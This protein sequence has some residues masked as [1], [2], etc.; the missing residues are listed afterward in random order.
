VL[1]ILVIMVMLGSCAAPSPHPARGSSTAP[2]AHT[3]LAVSVPLGGEV[4][5]LAAGGGYLWAY[6]RDTGVLV[7]VDQRTGQAWRFVL[8]A[9][10]GMPVVVA[11]GPH[12]L[13]LA[14]QHSTRPDLVLIDP[15][16]GRV[17][18]RPPLPGD[19]GPITG[20]AV[21]YGSLWI[22]VPDGAFPPGWRVLRLNPATSRVDGISADTP[23]TQLTG[24]TAAIWASLGQIWVTGSMPVIV[25]LDPR[26]LAL[27]ETATA[28]LSEGLVFGAGHAWALDTGRPQL[29]VVD[30]LTGKVIRTVTT[31]PP[32]T[33]GEDYV[34]AGTDLLW[35]FRGSRLSQLNPA[36]GHIMTSARIDPIAP[37]F[38]APAVVTGGGLWYLAQT[39]H[40]IVLDEIVPA[41]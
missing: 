15:H 28:D 5:G 10:R 30:P 3:R 25:R 13:W 21:G 14:N 17:A 36:T 37:A 6:A 1:P 32:S 12:G 23:G 24:H 9:W 29:A 19:S 31:P 4:D 26:T 7:R 40:G 27:H 18:A 11:A 16:T 33:T 8:G 41:P 39:G 22:L 20:L 34:V 35:V 2:A 38:Y